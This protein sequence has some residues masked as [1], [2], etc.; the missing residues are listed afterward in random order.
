MVPW[1]YVTGIYC[2]YHIILFNVGTFTHSCQIGALQAIVNHL[3][4]FICE[5]CH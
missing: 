3:F 5:L 2:C 1:L 4:V